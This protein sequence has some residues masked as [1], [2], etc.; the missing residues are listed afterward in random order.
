MAYNYCYT[1]MCAIPTSTAQACAKETDQGVNEKLRHDLE[2]YEKFFGEAVAE[3]N[4]AEI[5]ESAKDES[6]PITFSEYSSAADL[7]AN[8]YIQTYVVPLHVEEEQPFN[9]LDPN[10]VDLSGLVNAK[11]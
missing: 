10:Q 5:P 11:K 2:S 9:P 1:A 7:L 8:W 3:N 6:S 4:R